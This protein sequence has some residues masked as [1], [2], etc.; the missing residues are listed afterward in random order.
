MDGY[1]YAQPLI[2]TN[3]TIPGK[4]THNVVYVATEHDS[5]YAFDAEGRIRIPLW[6]ACL[7]G[8]QARRIQEDSLDHSFDG[9]IGGIVHYFDLDESGNIPLPSQDTGDNYLVA[10]EIAVHDRP[11]RQEHNG[12]L[13]DPKLLPVHPLAR[14]FD[15]TGPNRFDPNQQ[16]KSSVTGGSRTRVDPSCPTIGSKSVYHAR[17]TL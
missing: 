5:V 4:G 8:R 10:P 16:S 1:V 15:V 3:V 11:G 17:Q 7:T 12:L 9:W 2:L 13:S 6:H 14:P